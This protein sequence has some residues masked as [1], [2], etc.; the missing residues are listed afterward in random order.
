[1]YKQLYEMLLKSA[2]ADKTKAL[3]SLDLL[4]N[5]A[6]GIGDHS[7]DDYY[8]N[9]EQALQM[10]VDADDRIKTLNKYFNEGS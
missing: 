8:K 2:E 7:T 1:M 5:K 4:S 10:L 9:A 3:L 6:A